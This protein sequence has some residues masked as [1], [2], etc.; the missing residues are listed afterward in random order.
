MSYTVLARKYRSTNFDELV[1]Q[2]HVAGTLKRA[3]ESGRIA[4]A[5][6]F[7]GTR[8]TGKTS[9]ARILAKALNCQK[10]DGPTPEPCG[11]CNS[12]LAIAAGEDMD[13]IEIDGASNTGV[14]NVREVIIASAYNS[15][16]HS[17]F[18]VFIIDEVHMLSKSAFNALLKILEEPPA[19]VKFILATTEPEKVLPTILSRCQRYDF[20]SI[21]AKEIAGHLK[22]ICKKEKISA[23]D[24]AL[25]M[26][27]KAGA[28]SMRDALSLLDRLLSLGDKKLS[29]Q[30]VEQMLGLPRVQLIAEL[31]DSVGGGDVKRTLEQADAM[32]NSGLSADGLISALSDHLR[33]LLIARTCGKESGLL[34]VPGLSDTELADQAGKFDAVT[35]SQDIAI[36]EELRR[37]MR[38]S[39]TGR[40]M[41]D[42]TLVRL[43]LAKE[44][45][46]I[47]QLLA[48]PGPAGVVG[49]DSTRSV[50]PVVEQKKNVEAVRA[51]V[52]AA[53]E[54]PRVAPAVVEEKVLP[55]IVEPTGDLWPDLLA[56]LEQ[57]ASTM[58]NTLRMASLMGIQ[59]GQAVI[60]FP[61]H[62][63]TFAKQ[64]S[65]N[66]KKELIA[67]A[68]TELRGEPT[69]V[70]FEV[71]E[72]EAGPP[73]NV[74]VAAPVKTAI[75]TGV[76]DDPLV[77]LVLEEFGGRI[78]K[79]E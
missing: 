58:A 67:Q 36:L 33:N 1:G 20:R 44:F 18:K 2:D 12:C 63:E 25:A 17:R 3:I 10:A 22:E 19:H 49:S 26:V 15:P 16:A 24:D 42:A 64:W 13:V 21:S 40:A 76:Q 31:V 52:V 23:D 46:S 8:G 39:Q 53:V 37:T 72:V 78:A 27:A 66:G 9:T 4:H 65:N 61:Q 11:K 57:K 55:A 68:L 60:R 77:K 35:L 6:L 5:Y 56:R 75:D 43:A 69:G 50:S 14:D 62:L 79:V 41:L 48:S 70:K 71:G 30:N 38:Q 28:G 7:C 32:L 54:L 47:E 29:A 74:K 73:V 45:S 59:S 34:N 51:A